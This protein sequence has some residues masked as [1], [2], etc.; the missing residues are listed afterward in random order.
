M[1]LSHTALSTLIQANLT[2]A[3]FDVSNPHAQAV[4]LADAIAKAVVEHIQANAAVVVTS[5]SSTGSYKV[6]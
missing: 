5:G 6:S 1:A 4:V 3:G 2:V